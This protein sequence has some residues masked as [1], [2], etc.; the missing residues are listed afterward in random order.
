MGQEPTHG[1]ADEKADQVRH[2]R[3]YDDDP[4]IVVSGGPVGN[5]LRSVTDAKSCD[6]GY[7]RESRPAA[8]HQAQRQAKQEARQ[9]EVHDT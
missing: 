5:V 6:P 3:D 7:Q 4:R 8:N 2:E 9:T 1:G